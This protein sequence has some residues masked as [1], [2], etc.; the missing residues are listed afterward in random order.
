MEVTDKIL[1]TLNIDKSLILGMYLV[2]SNLWGTARK[3]SDLDVIIVIKNNNV[4]KG[5]KYIS[6]KDTETSI[7]NSNVDAWIISEN[8]FAEAIENHR[9]YELMC[10]YVPEKNKLIN[11]SYP[12]NKFTIN[13][14]ILYEQTLTVYTRD[15]EKAN[16]Q[17]GKNNLKRAEKILLHCTRNLF[18][19]L[20]L[21]CNGKIETFDETNKYVRQVWEPIPNN[22][23]A[24]QLKFQTIHDE[25]MSQINKIVGS[26]NASNNYNVKK[27]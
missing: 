21:L 18:L 23:Q 1:N 17:G 24:I 7:H 11:Y 26:T 27:K 8:K 15:W 5:N 10:L 14:K 12:N 19:T 9:M 20:Q 2:G 6:G 16:K 4:K 13:P 25:L 3:D 22:Y